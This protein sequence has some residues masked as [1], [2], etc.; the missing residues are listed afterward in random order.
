MALGLFEQ[1]RYESLTSCESVDFVVLLS[2]T[3]RPENKI[4]V[5][6][7]IFKTWKQYTT[8]FSEMFRENIV[9][10]SLRFNAL[11]HK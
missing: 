6:S 11:V 3:C 2:Y 10:T 4:D 9:M 7:G 5:A 1:C 8:N